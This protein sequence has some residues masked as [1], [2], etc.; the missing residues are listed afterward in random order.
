MQENSPYTTGLAKTSL[1]THLQ[2]LIKFNT[3]KKANPSN[4]LP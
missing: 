2:P 1:V 4:S 3:T